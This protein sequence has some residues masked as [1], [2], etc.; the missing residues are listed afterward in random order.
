[1]KNVRGFSLIELIVVIALIAI[2]SSISYPTFTRWHDRDAFSKETNLFSDLFDDVRTNTLSEKLCPSGNPSTAW[3]FELTDNNFS[4]NCLYFGGTDVVETVSLEQSENSFYNFEN[5]D[6]RDLP[7]LSDTKKLEISFF[8]DEKK[9]PKI[10]FNGAE[11]S[12]IKI[13]FS[14]TKQ[15]TLPTKHFYFNRVAGYFFWDDDGTRTF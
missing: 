12:Q 3:K 7:P 14:S 8:T 5:S 2:F 13:Q 9:L 11:Y 4:M 10:L 6:W 15:S 1:M